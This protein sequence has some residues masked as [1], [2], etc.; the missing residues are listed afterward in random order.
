[1]QRV[2]WVV[3]LRRNNP[4]PAEPT[5]ADV[6]ARIVG[7]APHELVD[8]M[9]QGDRKA[10]VLAED[11]EMSGISLPLTTAGRDKIVD[12]VRVCNIQIVDD[13]SRKLQG[14]LVAYELTIRG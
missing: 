4:S 13:S 7:Y 8:G 9:K 14:V 2:G 1:M 12:G 3:K 6:L 11:V 10:I 5:E